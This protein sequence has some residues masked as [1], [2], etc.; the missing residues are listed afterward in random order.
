MGGDDSAGGEGTPEYLFKVCLEWMWQQKV[1]WVKLRKGTGMGK[2]R[3]KIQYLVTDGRCSQLVRGFL[4]TTDVGRRVAHEDACGQ[5]DV[6]VV[7]PGAM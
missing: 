2:S 7:A 5:Q 6:R 4:T 3:F 1:L